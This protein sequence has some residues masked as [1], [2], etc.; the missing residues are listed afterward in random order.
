MAKHSKISQSNKQVSI[1]KTWRLFSTT[2]MIVHG[3]MRIHNPKSTDLL[4]HTAANIIAAKLTIIDK[5]M[6]SHFND[7]R[8]MLRT[9]GRIL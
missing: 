4:H 3:A 8:F 7:L 9:S 5:T 1:R 6:N 2:D